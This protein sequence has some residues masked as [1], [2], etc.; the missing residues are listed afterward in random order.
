VISNSEPHKRHA[1]KIIDALLRVASCNDATHS[2][3]VTQKELAKL[4]SLF[5][6]MEKELQEHKKYHRAARDSQWDEN[7][8]R[9]LCHTER[10]EARRM[11]CLAMRSPAESETQ[12]A[13]RMK[14]DCFGDQD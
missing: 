1:L 8:K 7:R 3:T 2:A 10:D 4:R 12:I 6:R 5:E 14:W 13:A 9:L 11:Y